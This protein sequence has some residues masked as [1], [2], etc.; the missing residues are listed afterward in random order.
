MRT[1]SKLETPAG[2][3]YLIASERGLQSAYFGRP[4][5]GVPMGRTPILAQAERELEEYF[6]GRRREFEIP[7]DVQGTPFQAKVW[8]VL[9]RIP[10]GQTLSYGDV[11]LR[12]GS[13]RAV[14][15]VGTANGRNPVCVLVPCHRVIAADGS[16]GGYSGGL[17]VKERLLALEG[18]RTSGRSKGF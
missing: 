13:P 4:E 12:I 10:Y 11:A 15:A 14:R 8:A 2:P 3:L 16:L 6:A 17:E 7:L 18:V 1:Q 9:A 5:A